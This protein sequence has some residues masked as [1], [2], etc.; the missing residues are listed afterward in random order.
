MDVATDRQQARNGPPTLAMVPRH[1]APAL[2]VTELIEQHLSLVGIL[3]SE[4]LRD[5]PAHVRVKT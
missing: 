2:D 4:R 1:A 3:V 5:V